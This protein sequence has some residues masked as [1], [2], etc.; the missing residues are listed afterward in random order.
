[1]L[2]ILK[3]YNPQREPEEINKNL[4]KVE[5]QIAELKETLKW[6]EELHTKAVYKIFANRIA[7]GLPPIMSK[8]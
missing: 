5:S 4:L 1:M 6:I 8:T 7:V 2:V 3:I